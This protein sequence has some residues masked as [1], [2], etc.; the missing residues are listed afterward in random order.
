MSDERLGVE[1]RQLFLADGEGH[2]RD[3]LRRDLLVAELLV[4]RHVRV[5]VD[6]RDDRG[7]LAGRA[8]PLDVGD[9]RLPVRVAERRVVDRDVRGGDA[10]GFEVRLEDL[11]RGARIHVVGA[12][13]H[14]ALHAHFV[15]QVVDR[16]NR[17]LVRRG[18][19]VDHVLG[20]LFALV[21]HRVEEQ[22][23]VLLEHRQHR[24]PGHR[25]PAAEDDRDLVLLEQLARLL[26]EER[27]VRGRID[28]DRLELPAEQ[29]ALLVLLVDEHQDRILERRLADGHR[30]RQRVQ[31][32]D[33]DG[34]L[35]R[36]HLHRKR[37]AGGHEARGR[38][39]FS[40]HGSLL[41]E[42]GRSVRDRVRARHICSWTPT[43]NCLKL[44]STASKRVS[45]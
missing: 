10:L 5:A 42:S 27:P 41:M 12:F 43:P 24:F 8:E 2:H 21:L 17:L 15:H 1:A 4:E 44:V 23:V 30:A 39:R 3:V 35:L 16:R 18:A 11:V 36:V 37:E 9:A 40:I 22:A 19:G 20:R 13:E 34:R 6:G 38:D 31:H 32:A 25:R 26:R 33:L 28:D 29:P 45:L 7:L 14:P